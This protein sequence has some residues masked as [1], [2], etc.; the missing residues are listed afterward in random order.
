VWVR[1]DARH[2][3][4]AIAVCSRDRI[5]CIDSYRGWGVYPLR[6]GARR[7]LARWCEGSSGSGAQSAETRD[8]LPRGAWR[9]R[10]NGAQVEATWVLR[11]VGAGG[12]GARLG[13][14]KCSS[15]KRAARQRL[16]DRSQATQVPSASARVAPY[17]TRG[18][19]A[20]T[21]GAR[22]NP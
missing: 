2:G 8:S 7:S 9:T 21:V 3:A 4:N 6:T 13:G 14:R 20:P 10:G 22:S 18:R 16:A 11:G 19:P 12:G 1:E 5:V 17:R 15:R